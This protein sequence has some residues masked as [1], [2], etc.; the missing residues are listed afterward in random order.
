MARR[1]V[2]GL[3]DGGGGVGSWGPHRAQSKTP[4]KP[5][6]PEDVR[7]AGTAKWTCLLCI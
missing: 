5:K 4:L 2:W 3:S 6:G 1:G 7:T